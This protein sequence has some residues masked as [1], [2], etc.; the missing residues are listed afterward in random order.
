M[1]HNKGFLRIE[2]LGKRVLQQVRRAGHTPKMLS[3][4]RYIHILTF[5]RCMAGE[6]AHGSL[7]LQ[8][9]HAHNSPDRDPDSPSL[10][11][12]TVQELAGRDCSGNLAARDG[13]SLVCESNNALVFLKSSCLETNHSEAHPTKSCHI[14]LLGQLSLGTTAAST[15]AVAKEHFAD[16][17]VVI[18][19]TCIDHV[20]RQSS[21]DAHLLLPRPAHDTQQPYR[22]PHDAPRRCT[23]ARRAPAVA[24]FVTSPPHGPFEPQDLKRRRGDAKNGEMP[25]SKRPAHDFSVSPGRVAMWQTM[26]GGRLWMMN[27]KRRRNRAGAAVRSYL[28]ELPRSRSSGDH[29]TVFTQQATEKMPQVAHTPSSSNGDRHLKSGGNSGPGHWAR[30]SFGQRHWIKA[31]AARTSGLTAKEP[32]TSP[33][34]TSRQILKYTR[35][36]ARLECG[37][38]LRLQQCGTAFSASSLPVHLQQ[39]QRGGAFQLE[40][41]TPSSNLRES[42]DLETFETPATEANGTVKGGEKKIQAAVG[43]CSG[44][45]LQAMAY[46][47]ATQGRTTMR[48]DADH[49]EAKQKDERLVMAKGLFPDACA[50]DREGK[51]VAG[52]ECKK[53]SSVELS[54]EM[55]HFGGGEDDEQDHEQGEAVD[56]SGGAMG[57]GKKG[58]DIVHVC[59]HICGICSKTFQNERG[60]KIHKTRCCPNIPLQTRLCPVMVLQTVF[61]IDFRILLHRI[62]R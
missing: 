28:A 1:R 13:T 47:S 46:C 18:S 6:T 39:L 21:S 53:I 29:M 52:D 32:E 34:T 36:E 10:T 11:L 58:Y 33:S 61:R 31:C 3:R 22:N 15:S 19:D 56:R 40:K 54:V 38:P 57:K 50:A 24:A 49:V 2:G 55:V 43:P 5:N 14:G 60:L 20:G 41:K 44:S 12:L 51:G 25:V 30:D 27:V 7:H 37:S 4:N 9:A 62:T 23:A 42:T 8:N 17:S 45:F 26:Q 48:I 35:L 16:S 59:Q